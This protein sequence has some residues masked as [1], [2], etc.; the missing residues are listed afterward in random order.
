VV[1]VMLVVLM[2]YDIAGGLGERKRIERNHTT[3]TKLLTLESEK[4]VV[5]KKKKNCYRYK[6]ILHEQQTYSPSPCAIDTV[7]R[8][9]DD[10][11]SSIC[12]DALGFTS[13]P[14]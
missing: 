9:D 5:Q 4:F 12:T 2:Q 1:A 3:V 7:E 11:R 14:G 6:R 8:N 13:M 10:P